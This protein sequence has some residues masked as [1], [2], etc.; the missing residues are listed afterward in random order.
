MVALSRDLPQGALLN[1]HGHASALQHLRKVERPVAVLLD[2]AEDDIKL[3][4]WALIAGGA[5]PC[6][7]S[8]LRLLPLGRS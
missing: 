2:Y 6:A 8:G 7:R 3:E 4:R 1:G 5:W